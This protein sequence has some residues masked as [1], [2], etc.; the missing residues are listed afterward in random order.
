MED[1]YGLT[2]K[3]EDL[4]GSILMVEQGR[5]LNSR[6][7]DTTISEDRKRLHVLKIAHGIK[8]LPYIFVAA[9]KCPSKLIKGNWDSL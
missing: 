1:I 2:P 4:E 5:M 9:L 8:T 7:V 6:E 3:I